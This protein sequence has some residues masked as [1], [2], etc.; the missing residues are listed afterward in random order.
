VREGFGLPDPAVRKDPPPVV[1]PTP[2]IVADRV[3]RKQAMPFQP[4]RANVPPGSET[5]TEKSQEQRR[6][7]AV[8]QMKAS[9]RG[10]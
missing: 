10:R 8:R 7:D 3:E 6:I 4:R 9:R 2:S 1:N 5:V